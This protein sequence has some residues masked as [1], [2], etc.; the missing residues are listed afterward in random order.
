MPIDRDEYRKASHDVWERIATNWDSER[1]YIYSATG[2][3]SRRMVERVAPEPGN[4]VRRLRGARD[5]AAGDRVA[6]RGRGRA[7]GL[8]SQA[9]GAARRC[10]RS[11]R[12]ERARVCESRRPLADRA[13]DRERPGP[14]A[15]PRGDD[16]LVRPLPHRPGGDRA[17]HCR[18]GRGAASGAESQA[19]VLAATPRGPRRQLARE[20][21]VGSL[22]IDGIELDPERADASR[23]SAYAV[24]LGE[25]EGGVAHCALCVAPLGAL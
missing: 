2:P 12:R 17:R 22:A 15:R 5:R 21:V 1:E 14:G 8:H 9:R 4:T 11:A 18:R 6:V 10:D 16:R 7:L 19:F 20:L 3:V 24:L 25:A 13:A 23:G